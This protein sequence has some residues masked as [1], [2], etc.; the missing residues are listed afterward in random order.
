MTFKSIDLQM[1]IPRTQEFSGMHGQAIHKPIADQ[2]ML[3]AQTSKHT[4]QIRRKNSG[5]EQAAGFHVHSEHEGQQG[6]AYR[7]ARRK[8]PEAEASDSD[9][10]QSPAHP[11]KGHKL[12]IKL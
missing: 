9:L 12:D 5:I 4:E 1:S 2:N 6:N 3:A 7:N 8:R 10:E 11:F